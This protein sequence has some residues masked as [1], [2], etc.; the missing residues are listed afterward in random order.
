M[1]DNTLKAL[2][3]V[4]WGVEA[5]HGTAVPATSRVAVEMIDWGDDDEVLFTPKVMNGLMIRDVGTPV[6]VKHG[7]RFSVGDQPMIW[8]QVPHWLSMAINGDITPTGGTGG[9]PFEWDFVR[10]PTAL[11]TPDTFTFERRFDNGSGA[12][13]D[14]SMAYAL[15]SKIGFKYAS[16]EPVRMNAEGFARKFTAMGGGIT[17]ALTLPDFLIAPSSLMEI[18]LD[19]EWGDLGD[20]RLANQVIGWSLDFPTGF[21]PLMSLDGRT[22]LDFTTHKMDPEQVTLDLKMTVLCD[23]TFYAAEQ[24]AA[25]AGDIRAV[26][27]SITD[28]ANDRLL[29]FDMLVRHTKPSLFKIG[30]DSGQDILELQFAGASDGTNF[31][32]AHYEHPTIGDLT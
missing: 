32:A 22:D 26:R 14:Q 25:A 18:W 31:F 9:N 17:A 11:P 15:L 13:I 6:P 21:Y 2:R 4:Q 16:G 28:A 20:T 8:E 7:T 19:D 3:I 12:T 10:D 23:P 24:A 29:R 27:A 5:T 30:E 1:T